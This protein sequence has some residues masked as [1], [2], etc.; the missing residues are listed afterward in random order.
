M[1]ATGKRRGKGFLESLEEQLSAI[2]RLIG[3][4]RNQESNDVREFGFLRF[5]E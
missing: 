4:K 1:D 5:R 2:S 3:E